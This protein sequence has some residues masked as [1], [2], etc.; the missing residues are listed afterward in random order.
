M[1]HIMLTIEYIL[2]ILTRQLHK[3]GVLKKRQYVNLLTNFPLWS[4]A[5]NWWLSFHS[6]VPRQIEVADVEQEVERFSPT[7]IP[8]A[9]IAPKDSSERES[10]GEM[11]SAW[12]CASPAASQERKVNPITGKDPFTIDINFPPG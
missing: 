5:S 3:S 7:F 12:A 9:W 1:D 2:Y 10:G 4:K 11:D 8:W 6:K